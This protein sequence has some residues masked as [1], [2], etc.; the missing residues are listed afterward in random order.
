MRRNKDQAGK[1]GFGVVLPKISFWVI[2]FPFEIAYDI[3]LQYNTSF[4]LDSYATYSVG[5]DT[6]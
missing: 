2:A 3:L 4:E 5:C 1:G 6:T